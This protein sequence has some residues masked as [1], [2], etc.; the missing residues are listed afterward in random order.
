MSEIERDKRERKL[1]ALM[2]NDLSADMGA[3]KAS[4]MRR[5]VG[6]LPDEELRRTLARRMDLGDD[7]A[8]ADLDDAL[9]FVKEPEILSDK[10]SGE[11]GDPTDLGAAPDMSHGDDTKDGGA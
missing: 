3:E 2:L 8:E 5:E 9:A 6:E 10:E 1:V 4:G 11:P 7:V